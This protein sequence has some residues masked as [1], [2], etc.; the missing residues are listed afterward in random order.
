MSVCDTAQQ[1]DFRSA[2]LFGGLSEEKRGQA[3]ITN[4]QKIYGGII[5]PEKRRRAFADVSLVI[6]VAVKT[7]VRNAFISSL[8]C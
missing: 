1:V 2:A 6:N 8:S 3:A 7:E 4:P 5:W